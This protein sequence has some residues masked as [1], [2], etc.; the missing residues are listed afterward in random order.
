MGIAILIAIDIIITQK[1]RLESL[2]DSQALLAVGQKI[3]YF[4]MIGADNQVL[5]VSVLNRARKPVLLFIPKQPCVPCNP[6][7]LLWKRMAKII[8]DHADIYGIWLGK[9][10]DMIEFQ[11]NREF[12]FK[13]YSPVDLDRIKKEL[14]VKF[15]YPQTI[16]YQDN[17]VVLV[18]LGNLEGHDFAAILNRVKQYAK[19]S[20]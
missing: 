9:P 7:F 19:S 17:K 16:L 4:D 11:E 12:Y 3:N 15:N 1:H 14:K 6:N 5:D 8:Q 18:K 13:F 2:E 20:S 10:S